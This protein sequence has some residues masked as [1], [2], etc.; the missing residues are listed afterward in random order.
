MRSFE[1]YKKS[2]QIQTQQI[3]KLLGFRLYAQKVIGLACIR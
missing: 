3:Q 2:K 1:F